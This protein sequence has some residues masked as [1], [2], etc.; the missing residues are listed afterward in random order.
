[1]TLSR[2]FKL[3]LLVLSISCV[4]PNNPLR[5]LFAFAGIGYLVT[6]SLIPKLM[7]S[8]IKIGLKGKDLSKP[9]PVTE[10]AESMGVVCAVTYLFLMFWLIPFVFFKYLVS[11]TSMSDD[12]G[13][14]KNYQSQYLADRKSVV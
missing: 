4:T 13:I 14:S 10:I 5:T 2:I 1:M 6:A 12:A 11:F 9:P 8:F 3:S 7:S